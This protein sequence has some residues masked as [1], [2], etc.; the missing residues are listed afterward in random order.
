MMGWART[1]ARIDSVVAVFF[2]FVVVIAAVSPTGTDR[3]TVTDVAAT[4]G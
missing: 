2:A 3:R 1:R 4:L